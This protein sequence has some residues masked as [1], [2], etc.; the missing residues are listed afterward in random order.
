[1]V[2]AAED[3]SE[4]DLNSQFETN[5]YGTLHILQ[6]SLPYF[7]TNK[8]PGRYL[9][10]SST[11]GAL[12]VPGLAGYCAT[13]YAVE[14]LIESMLYEVHCFGIKVTLV[15]PGHVASD[16]VQRSIIF[17]IDHAQDQ[18][19]P[20][21][22]AVQPSVRHY[23]HFFVKP[24]PSPPYNNPTSPAGH[25]KRI[26]QWLDTRQPTSAVR[27]AELVWQLAH[28]SYPPLRLLLGNYAVESIRDRLK[29]VTEEIE[30]WKFLSFAALESSK[31]ALPGGERKKSLASTSPSEGDELEE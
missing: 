17:P 25:A 13:K 10:F 28:C 20:T 19:D 5:F 30:D 9:I 29:C 27:T 24:N 6:L 2:A 15:E 31:D 21:P 11:A 16:D 18:R 12:G 4:Q 3:Q 14:G 23:G 8:I 7:R 26:F 22:G 1:M